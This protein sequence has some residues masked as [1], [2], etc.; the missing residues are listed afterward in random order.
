MDA[1]D[2][3]KMDKSIGDTFPSTTSVCP[4]LGLME[5]PPNV[6]GVTYLRKG[7]EIFLGMNGRDFEIYFVTS[8]TI[9][10]KTAAGIGTRLVRRLKEDESKLF[11]SNPQTWEI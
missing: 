3:I 7:K 1:F 5:S 9:P 4:V 10:V 6:H 11:L 8:N 2:M